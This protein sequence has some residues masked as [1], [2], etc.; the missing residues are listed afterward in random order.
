MPTQPLTSAQ[1]AK[2][3]NARVQQVG[4]AAFAREV[5]LDPATIHRIRHGEALG[6]KRTFDRI[7]AALKLRV[8]WREYR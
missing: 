2:L 5:G 6:S 8:T 3:V 7:C 1:L 4:Q